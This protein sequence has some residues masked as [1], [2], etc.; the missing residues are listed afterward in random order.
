MRS[1]NKVQIL[2]MLAFCI[3]FQMCIIIP[4]LRSSIT[5]VR[6]EQLKIKH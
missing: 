4:L 2:E 3:N 6:K 1:T 5:S